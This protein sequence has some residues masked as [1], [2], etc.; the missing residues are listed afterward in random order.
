MKNYFIK[1]N[2]VNNPFFYN[3]NTFCKEF[4]S[5]E[6][7]GIYSGLDRKKNLLE[8]NLSFVKC[9]YKELFSYQVLL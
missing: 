3:L 8:K 2:K 7:Q 9:M 1:I 4:R 6:I 5:Q